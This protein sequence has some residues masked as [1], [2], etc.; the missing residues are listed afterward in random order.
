MET[1]YNSSKSALKRNKRP[2]ANPKMLVLLVTAILLAIPLNY[3]FSSMAVILFVVYSLLTAKKEDFTIN[4]SLMLPVA[5][6][7]L[8]AVSLTW[9]I[10]FKSTLKAL[11]KEISLFIIPIVFC[12]NRLWQ[13]QLNDILRFFSLGMFCYGIFYFARAALA[14]FST[15]DSSV[16]FYHSL[17][18]DDVN[19]IYASA[20]FSVA[21][22]YYLSRPQKKLFDYI[23]A[24]F[25][26]FLLFLL[27]SKNILLIDILL[28]IVYFL[29]FSGVSK[30][31]KWG[32]VIA[33]CLFIAAMGYNSKI[34]ARIAEE[35]AV[36]ET[37][38]ESNPVPVD[39]VTIHDAWNKETFT[40][41][42]YF[43]GTALR[44]YQIRIFT[45]MLQEDPIFFTGYGLNASYVKVNEK[46]LEHNIYK[47]TEDEPGYH[48]YNFHNQYVEVFADLGVFGVLIVILMMFFNIKNGIS[49][50]DFVH[51]AFAIVMIALFLTESFLWRQR[52][53]IFFTVLY[54]LFN[55]G[56]YS[57]AMEKEKK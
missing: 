56:L 1:I 52:G 4:T 13:K 21:F 17:V 48:T 39:K 30:K 45:E 26:F 40:Q 28:I 54:C 15:G 32:S 23:G 6:F 24:A 14:Y 49:N 9:S 31:A 43:S 33:F 27:S 7:L 2:T 16:F 41:N 19:A 25:I 12:F 51:I 22:F 53:V 42:D 20:F 47:G 3:G 50:K 10:D 34:R 37:P 38:S 5:L 57:N 11:S 55:K 36:Q 8:M 46:G 35:F 29:F 44:V 18:T